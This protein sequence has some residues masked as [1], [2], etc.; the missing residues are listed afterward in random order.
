MRH[1]KTWVALSG[2]LLVSC[3]L[4]SCTMPRTLATLMG[5][6]RTVPEGAQVDLSGL[7]RPILNPQG[8]APTAD[9]ELDSALSGPRRVPAG[10]QHQSRIGNTGNTVVAMASGR[11]VPVENLAFLNGRNDAAKTVDVALNRTPLNREKESAYLP[12]SAA[13]AEKTDTASPVEKVMT[14]S[15]STPAEKP[16]QASA[17]EETKL[18]LN[19]PSAPIPQTLVATEGMSENSQQ[20]EKPVVVAAADEKPAA[21]NATESP[22]AKQE[23]AAEVAEAAKAE[24]K[25]LAK[26]ATESTPVKPVKS[27]APKE[28]DVAAKAADD[29]SEPKPAEHKAEQKQDLAAIIGNDK[30]SDIIKL[31]PP[32][33]PRPEEMPKSESNAN[34]SAVTPVAQVA[35]ASV[36]D[37]QP[38]QIKAE[39][40]QNVAMDKEEPVGQTPVPATTLAQNGTASDDADKTPSLASVP[41]APARTPAA[42]IASDMHALDEAR[43]SSQTA[44]QELMNNKDST[45]MTSAVTGQVVANAAKAE[46]VK[47]VE[48]KKPASDEDHSSKSD[49]QK[50]QTIAATTPAKADVVAIKLQAPTAAEAKPVTEPAVAAVQT[51]KPAE[52][53]PAPAVATTESKPATTDVATTAESSLATLA[54]A[55]G[56]P[57]STV[58]EA[59]PAAA[60][61]SS[62]L[63]PA[64]AVAVSAQPAVK[65]LIPVAAVSTTSAPVQL[66]APVATAAAP[67]TEAQ[68]QIT[69]IVSDAKDSGET[70]NAATLAVE[71]QVRYLPEPRYA[72]RRLPPISEAY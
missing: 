32:S 41:E 7:H 17:A 57:V 69:D 67:G 14:A 8:N 59:P 31:S 45:V 21:H 22:A 16:A 65:E 18:V 62:A 47:G 15:L 27:E 53:Q 39:P 49:S 19:K 5:D 28:Q 6:E 61:Q 42:Q 72:E 54:P 3:A 37:A 30:A 70:P 66:H 60:I 33:A 55:A 29:W 44:G 9:E 43:T 50:A 1:G 34:T 4:S 13:V 51:A 63:L 48:S 36:V 20:Q 23:L 38:T 52:T 11:H 25:Q 10:N 46:P 68:K 2:V 35:K 26:V 58:T 71:K 64:P 40:K 12:A 56:S 24:E